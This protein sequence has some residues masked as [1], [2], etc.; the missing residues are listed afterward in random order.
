MRRFECVP[1]VKRGSMLNPE[2]SQKRVNHQSV[3]I[4][5]RSLIVFLLLLGSLSAHSLDSDAEIEFLLSAIGSS[6]CEFSRNG[7]V[8]S[9]AEAESHLRMKYDNG[10]RYVSSAE[11]FIDR[12]ASKSSI[13]RRP[14]S[15]VCAEG[16]TTLSSDWLYN[17]LN[18]YRD[19]QPEG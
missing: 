9:A 2:S 15:I 7:S 1:K 4:I 12:L 16:V 11:Q 18:E 5:G 3:N 17:K 6:G 10:R 19:N 8:H 13:T 14:Y